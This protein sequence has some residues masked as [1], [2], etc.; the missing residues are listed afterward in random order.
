[1]KAIRQH[2]FGGP[3]TAGFAAIPATTSMPDNSAPVCWK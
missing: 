2:E 1:M 3:D